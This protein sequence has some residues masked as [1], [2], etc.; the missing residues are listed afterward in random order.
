MIVLTAVMLLA[1]DPILAL[2]TLL[3]FPLIAWLVHQVRNRLRH[4]LQ[5]GG[6]AWSEMTSVLADTIPGIRVVKAFAQ[7]HRE[8]ERFRTSNDHVLHANDR[9][10][11]TWSFFGPM[12]NLLTQFGLLIVWAF[13]AWRVYQGSINAGILVGVPA[14]DQPL[15][16]PARVDEPDGPGDAASGH[17]HAAAL[18]NPR[19]GSQRRR[20]GAPGPSRPA[21][22]GRSSFARS[23]FRHGNRTILDDIN[24]TIRP[25]EMIGL[26]GPTRGGQEHA[27][28]PRL[29]V[30]RRRRRRD[31]RRRHRHP[32][33]PGVRIPPEH[34]HRAPGTVPV[35][36]HDRREHRLRP[37][38]TP[39]RE[40]IIAAARAAGHTSS[41]SAS[42]TATTRS[43]ASAASRSRAA[44]G[45]GSRS[46]GPS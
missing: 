20:A 17:E 2:A 38:R 36:R 15:L 14:L 4:G 42:P 37:A 6:R 33:V 43:S 3:P 7:E 29:P 5:R 27:G 11:D 32:L 19:P 10:N 26:V 44:N 9:V 23:A 8:V 41:S 46:P 35:L 24:L 12:V 40:E 39:R 16:H 13:G 22:R 34:R 31:P 1:L 30:L 18:R 28:Q 45:S 21:S 25:G